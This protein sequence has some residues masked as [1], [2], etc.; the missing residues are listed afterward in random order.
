M[1]PVPNA[2]RVKPALILKPET[3]VTDKPSSHLLR[4]RRFWPLFLLLQTGTFNDNALKNALIG[5]ITFGGVAFLSN[6]DSAVRV[7]VA[8][9]IFTG[10][11]LLVCAIAGQIADKFD[12]GQILRWVKRAEVLIMLIAAIGFWWVNIYILT[13]ALFCMGAQSAFFSPTKNSVLPYWLGDEELIAGNALLNG[14]VFVFVLIGMIAG[15]FLIGTDNG[16]KIIAVLLLI[17]AAIGW[18]A[19]EMCLPAPPPTPNLK[20]NFEPISATWSVLKSAFDSPP[21]LRPMLGISWFYGLSTVIVTTLPDYISSVMGYDRTVLIFIL[22]ASTLSILVGSLLCSLLSK[23]GN[24][25]HESVGL[26]AFGIL[27]VLVFILD[28]FLSATTRSAALEDG[29]LRNLDVFFAQ[30]GTARFMADVCLSSIGGGLFV[31]PL[32]A[33]AQRRADPKIRAR[34]M[35]AGAVL[36]NLFVNIVTIALIYMGAK[37]LPP[38]SPFLIIIVGSAVVAVYAS[39]RTFNPVNDAEG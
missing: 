26:S 27:I 30:E 23:R 34:L 9:F 36:L 2:W 1:S 28:L 25:G 24:W 20:V 35:S 33:M 39:W 38:K 22:V 3:D 17:L 15:L 31:V 5:L 10:P 29:T 12:R 21:V 16:P 19:S 6:L 4:Q 14:F 13:F 11:F 8:A 37:A 32:Q 7:P 18:W